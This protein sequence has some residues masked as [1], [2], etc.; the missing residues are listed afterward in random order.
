M[1]NS[2]KCG[3]L[4]S[5]KNKN[6]FTTKQKSLFENKVKTSNKASSFVQ[7]GLKKSVQTLSGN[8]SLKLSSTLNPFVDQFGKLGSY[9]APR[10]FSDIERDCELLW[11]EDPLKASKFIGYLRTI[12]RKVKLMTGETT[13][14]PQLG[15]ELKHESIF[16]MIWL[17]QKSPDTFWANIDLFVSLG[18]WHDVF[19]MLQYDLV[20][21]GWNNRK[22][23]WAKFGE[24][25][26][27]A[28]GN[29]NTS[30][31]V[32]KY[33]PQ[34]KAKSAC[35]TVESQANC[36]IA[37]WICSLLFGSKESASSYKQYRKL[38]TSGTAHDWQK[39][40]SQKKFSLIDFGKIHG[41][42][43]NKLVRSKFLANQ[44]L[45]EKYGSWVKKATDVKY[46]G[47]VHELFNALPYNLSGIPD[48]QQDTINKQFDTLVQKAKNESKENQCN[49]IVVRDTSGSMSSTATGTTMSCYN[50]GKALALYFSEFLTGKFADS[51]I[52]FNSDAE[53]HTW[54]GK[55][56][57]EKWY[58]DHSN[59]VGS[60]NFLSVLKLFVDIK[61]RG[62]SEQDFPTGILC[63][64]DSEFNPS[65]LNETNVQGARRILLEG[66]FSKDF[67]DRFQIVLWNLQSSYYGKGTGEKFE[68]LS[69]EMGTFYFSGFGSSTISF[70]TGK[71]IYTPDQLFDAA[72]NQTI[73]N[74]IKLL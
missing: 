20:Y 46:T 23:N 9:K 58:N 63:I 29:S 4:K 52:E 19:T 16:R 54:K 47:F 56:P 64:S 5:K 59:Y 45:T 51:W 1:T 35:T 39:L 13:D 12:P 28:L 71:E 49:F 22:L 21:N 32:K 69:H 61:Q 11:V 25:I 27:Q 7:A 18:S 55:T 62:V 33:L 34:I 38:K 36:M 14:E 57:L 72:M 68:T 67:V 2:K 70:L 43:L 50:I 73:L 37:K 10:S 60:T 6:M 26:L 8:G 74:M 42:A 30:E 66:G 48:H 31:L 24:L 17:S 53:M 41:R 3:K 40:I 15:A 44:G 65:Q